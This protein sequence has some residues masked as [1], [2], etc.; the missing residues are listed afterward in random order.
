MI[1]RDGEFAVPR[2]HVPQK[3]RVLREVVY[4]SVHKVS[5]RYEDVRFRFFYFFDD[6]LQA[7]ASYDDSDMDIGYLHDPYPSCR[8]R[9]FGRCYCYFFCPYIL[10]LKIAVHIDGR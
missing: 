10:C 7:F 2:M 3:R 4:L 8:L 1:A 9:D 6:V 5:R